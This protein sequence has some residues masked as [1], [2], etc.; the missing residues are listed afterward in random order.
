MANKTKGK[1]TFRERASYALYFLGQN[2]FY[3]LTYMF[4]NTYF[5]DVGI[6]TMAVAAIVLV[7]KV[8][9]A[10]NDPIFG[11]LIDKVKF[12]KGGIFVPWLRI[13]VY[14]VFVASIL[15]FAI[16]NNFPMWGKVTWA[17]VAY[18][19]WSVGYTL[20]D[21]PIFGLITTI[22]DD[23]NERITL[24]AIGR[25][26]A[27]IAVL[28]TMIIIPMFRQALGG[29]TQTIIVLSII[30]LATM[31]PI[32][33]TAKERCV[34][35]GKQE[36]VSLKAMFKYLTHNKFLFI[37]YLAF[38][39]AG[40]F[41]IASTWNMY[42]ARY[43]FNGNETMVTVT[44]A[45]GMIPALIVGAFIPMLCRK[46][47]KFK[48][49][50]WATVF[51]AVTVIAKWLV[52]YGSLPAYIVMCVLAGLPTGFTMVLGYMFTPDCAE[53]GRFMTGTNAPGIT[54]ATQTFFAKLQSA[55]V[56]TLAAL[57][58]GFTGFVAGE[59]AVQPDGFG[60]TLWAWSNIVPAIGYA[61][62]IVVLCFYK[63]N[64]KDVQIMAK[65]NSGEITREEAEAQLSRKY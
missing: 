42:I 29:W 33:F 12:K 4:L 3:M 49:Y 32:G 31:I 38:L 43:C 62:A 34:P 25:E 26:S 55:L 45:A 56:S 59:G 5:T 2:I 22:T 57:I 27:L 46:V 44:T 8:W 6:T 41:N 35:E 20:N 54:F 65:C 24:N 36:S 50:F 39:I 1:V 52:G 19:L 21:V 7:V 53:Y 23:Q 47:D 18:F 30:G 48:L 37:Y 61:I 9:D 28:I 40:T 16:P 11:A 58:L 17:I 64:D 51:S 14:I 63:L 10:V 13:A 15:L 60:Q